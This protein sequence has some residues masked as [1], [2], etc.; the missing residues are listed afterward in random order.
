MVRLRED[1]LNVELAMV[2]HPAS[3]SAVQAAKEDQDVAATAPAI[4]EQE[5]KDAAQRRYIFFVKLESEDQVQIVEGTHAEEPY[6]P[7]VLIIYDGGSPVARCN[8]VERWFRR[9]L[10]GVDGLRET[11]KPKTTAEQNGE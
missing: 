6:G 11:E 1:F 7:G 10:P 8:R 2:S 3:L 9:Q 5:L 4:T